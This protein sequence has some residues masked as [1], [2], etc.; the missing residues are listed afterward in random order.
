MNCLPRWKPTFGARFALWGTPLA[1]CSLP[2]P[3]LDLAQVPLFLSSAI[4]PNILVT[5]D[6]SQ[7]MDA[8]MAGKVISGDKPETRSNI[9]REVL[10]SYA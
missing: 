3:A 1:F 2:A 10:R 6:N 9:A 5:L 4:T 8:T 7:S